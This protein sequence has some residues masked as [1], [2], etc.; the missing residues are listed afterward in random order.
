MQLDHI[1]NTY[2]CFLVELFTGFAIIQVSMTK[3]GQSG[4]IYILSYLICSSSI[5]DRR[6]EFYTQ[7]LT[8]PAQYSFIYLAEVHTAWHPERVQYNIN[9][10]SVFQEWH[11]FRTHDLCHDTFVP[12]TARHLISH[13]QLTL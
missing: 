10:C 5:E 11:V 8:C 12:V 13:F 7:L 3:T 1:N 4:I 6:S 2:G 9:R